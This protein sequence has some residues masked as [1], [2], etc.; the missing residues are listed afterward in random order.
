[1]ACGTGAAVE[2]LIRELL[3]SKSVMKLTY[4]FR[5]DLSMLHT[6]FPLA[7]TAGVCVCDF[8]DALSG[9]RRG[10]LGALVECVFG[11]GLDKSLQ[12]CRLKLS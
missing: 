1:M 12:V 2:T 6:T 9:P 3:E 10:G 8:R 4:A 5:T 7:V 11:R